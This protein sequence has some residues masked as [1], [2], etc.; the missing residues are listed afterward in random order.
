MKLT[1]FNGKPF[2]TCLEVK[3]KTCVVCSTE[4]KPFSGAHKFCS[5]QCKGKFKYMSEKVT[6]K[7]QYKEISGNWE[8]YL[9]RLLYSSG[10]KRDNLTKED[11][12]FILHKQDKK[13][14]ISGNFL[15][16]NLE[17]GIKFWTN[18]SVDRI[19]AG[20][21]YT[22]DNIQLVCRAVNSWRSDMP[23]ETFIEVCRAVAQ[24]NPKRDMEVQDG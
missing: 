21:S 12:L 13:C 23:L 2:H 18:A 10:R 24:H 14:A 1:S 4:F 9:S 19:D 7:S 6:T 3:L 17:K 11:L 20:G 15:T 8:R 5:E 16:C 22:L